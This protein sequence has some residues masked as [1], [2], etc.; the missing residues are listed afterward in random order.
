MC[1]SCGGLIVSVAPPPLMGRPSSVSEGGVTGP[2]FL[3]TFVEVPF[4]CKVGAA[5][6]VG[7]A[8]TTMGGGCKVNGLMCF[9][10]YF[11]FY[12]LGYFSNL[13]AWFRCGRVMYL[14]GCPVWFRCGVGSGWLLFIKIKIEEVSW[15][16]C[17]W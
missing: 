1:E 15:V 6:S 9:L 2:T 16:C 4:R 14:E 12:A 3:A 5:R 11:Y 13:C 10:Q 17:S 8:D 7:V